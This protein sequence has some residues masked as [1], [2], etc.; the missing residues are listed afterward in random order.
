MKKT[1]LILG[2]ELAVSALI[3]FI[4]NNAVVD[5]DFF[6][7]LGLGNLVIGVVGAIAGLIIANASE[8]KDKSVLMASGLLLLLGCLTCSFFPLNINGSR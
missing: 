8:K 3:A 4:L 5:Y 7:A 2:I 1:T 6:T